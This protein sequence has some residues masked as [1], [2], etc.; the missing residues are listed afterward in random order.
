VLVLVLVVTGHLS[1]HLVATHLPKALLLIQVAMSLF[2]L[3]LVEQVPL[4]KAQMV[5]TLFLAL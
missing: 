5:L 3:V 2:P 1:Q 4:A